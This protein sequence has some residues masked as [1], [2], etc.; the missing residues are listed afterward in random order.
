M[1]KI[2]LAILIAITFANCNLSKKAIPSVIKNN[3]ELKTGFVLEYTAN[4]RGFYRKITIQNQVVIISNDRN[5]P[6]KSDRIAVSD[7]DWSELVA[8]FQVLNLEALADFK[9][10]TQ[11]RLYDGAATGN[12]NVTY[13]GNLFQSNGFDHGF[14][15]AEIEKIVVKMNS[16][17]K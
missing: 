4:T 5:A 15:P 2:I 12:L 10:P 1:K 13:K 6:E 16:F 14:P 8:E 3:L 9:A 11:K 17:A 7:S